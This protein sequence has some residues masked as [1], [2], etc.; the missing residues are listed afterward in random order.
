MKFLKLFIIIVSI[1]VLI[2]I[3]FYVYENNSVK[4]GIFSLNYRIKKEIFKDDSERDFHGSGFSIIVDSVS[5]QDINYFT[6]APKDF[7][8][9]YPKKS[10]HSEEF[11][12]HT[13]EKTPIDPKDTSAINFALILSKNDSDSYVFKNRNIVLKYLGII[14]SK[15]KESDNLYCYT[16][17]NHPNKLYGVDFY[18]ID[19]KGHL[20]YSVNKQ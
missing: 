13:W 14:K 16:F 17:R 3:L 1:I 8:K 10:F 9:Y 15:L 20:I 12:V 4:Q 5:D 18:L 6:N 11:K 7:Y 2:L 19:L